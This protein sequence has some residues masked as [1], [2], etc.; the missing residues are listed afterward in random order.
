MSRGPLI[1]RH[2]SVFAE[3]LGFLRFFG[4][5]VCPC[6]S[7][8]WVLLTTPS[9]S[10][11]LP[12]HSYLIHPGSTVHPPPIDGPSPDEMR[13]TAVYWPSLQIGLTWYPSRGDQVMIA[14]CKPSIA[15]SSHGDRDRRRVCQNCRFLQVVRSSLRRGSRDQYRFRIDHVLIMYA[16]HTDRVP[17][18]GH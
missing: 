18:R 5:I 8:S 17:M 16:G 10:A 2:E 14:P 12:P 15:C 3:M 9:Q 7:R 1:A 4:S 13:T 11:G 6:L